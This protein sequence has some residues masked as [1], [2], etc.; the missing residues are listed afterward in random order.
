MNPVRIAIVLALLAAPLLA[1][2]AD[3][4]RRAAVDPRIQTIP[5]DPNQ[6]TVLRGTLGFQFMIEFAAD[7]HIDTVSVGDSLGWQVTPNRKANVLFIKPIDRGSV[8]NLTVLTDQRRYAF[9]L[10]VAPKGDR[11]P[12]LFIARLEY[13][14]P[15]LLAP[16]PPPPPPEAPPVVANSAYSFTG[17][18]ESRPARVF[19]DGR[20]TYFEWPSDSAVS[21]IFAV[22]ADGAETLVN[23][24]VRGSLT[25]V[26]QLA[27][28]FVLRNGASVIQVVNNGYPAAGIRP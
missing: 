18:A 10:K 22:S 1:E 4:P 17:A 8:T 5:Y 7:E 15:A 21:A 2:A 27:P 13:P 26:E 24:A 19:D 23:S 14:Q 16:A 6:I 9:E 3:A 28:R 20:Q 11:A 12:V 25:V